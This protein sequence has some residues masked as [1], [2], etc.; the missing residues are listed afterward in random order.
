MRRSRRRSAPNSRSIG[1]NSRVRYAYPAAGV[2]AQPTMSAQ[3]RSRTRSVMSNQ[4]T[5]STF[6]SAVIARRISPAACSIA[7]RITPPIAPPGADLLRSRRADTNEA[8][9][10]TRE[11]GVRSARRSRLL[12]NA[13]VDRRDRRVVRGRRQL[14]PDQSP[15]LPHPDH[16]PGTRNAGE[17]LGFEPDRPDHDP[18]LHVHPDDHHLPGRPAPLVDGVVARRQC[19]R[20]LVRPGGRRQEE[21]ETRDAKRAHDHSSVMGGDSPRGSS[22]TAAVARSAA[23]DTAR[24]WNLPPELLLRC[25]RQVAPRVVG[26]G[27]Q[28]PGLVPVAEV[29]L[30]QVAVTAEA[31][32]DPP[33][34][35]HH[36]VPPAADLFETEG[37]HAVPAPLAPAVGDHPTAVRLKVEAQLDPEAHRVALQDRRGDLVEPGQLV[38]LLDPEPPGL[39][40]PRRRPT[41]RRPLARADGRFQTRPDRPQG[42]ERVR[43]QRPAVPAAVDLA[44]PVARAEP[45]PAVTGQGPERAHYADPA[46]AHAGA[47]S[48]LVKHGRGERPVVDGP[49]LGPRDRRPGP[50]AG[51]PPLRRLRGRDQA[52]PVPGALLIDVERGHRPTAFRTASIAPAS[53]S[54]HRPAP[55]TRPSLS[56]TNRAGSS[57]AWARYPLSRTAGEDLSYAL[58]LRPQLASCWR[59]RSEAITAATAGESRSWS[60]IST[61]QAPS[62]AGGRGSG[63][64]GGTGGGVGPAPWNVTL[65]TVGGCSFPPF[66]ALTTRNATPGE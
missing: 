47:L 9:R 26:R 45:L 48:P 55:A 34:V 31:P 54:G 40:L 59:N 22:V 25:R 6:P 11:D 65:T 63:G 44:V 66:W 58:N 35:L 4:S 52:E 10:R 64:V 37:E 24:T 17:R 23:R 16:D 2:G 30:G 62:L 42:F 19:C 20:R 39:V 57:F 18:G 49:P 43:H 13:E 21:N 32:A 28:P 7:L 36:Q 56:R 5:A 1:P 3:T 41:G 8:W 50:D 33:R 12:A 61:T 38:R 27:L 15:V 60:A 53:V 51:H 46:V 14:A 29:R